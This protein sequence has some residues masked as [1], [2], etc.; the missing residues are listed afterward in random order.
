LKIAI[1]GAG[2]AGNV[3]ARGLHPRHDLTV[4]EA[5]NHIGGHS[6]TH[7]VEVGGR[8]VAVDTGFIVYNDATYPRFS[9]LLAGLGV[10]SQASSMSF[11]VRNEA[12]GLE[13]NGSTINTLFAQ[14]RNLLR[15]SF[16]RMWRD[17][18]RFNRHAPDILEH[19]A[20]HDMTLGDFVRAHN[21]SRQFVDDY[22]LPMASAIWSAAPADIGAMPARFLIGFFRNHG[23][24]SVNDRPQWRTVCGGSEQY[25]ER[26]VAPFRARIHLRTPVAGVRRAEGRVQLRL[27]SGETRQFD[28]VFF[29]CHSDQALALLED[30]SA[31]ERSILGAIPYQENEVV[32]H[33]DA[34][35]L[36]LRRRAWAAWNYHVPRT[37]IERVCVTYNMNILQALDLPQTLC[38]TLNRSA[39]IDPATIL[40]RIV[41]H[42]PLFTGTAVAAQARLHEINGVNGSYFCGAYWRYGFHE[43]GVVSGE[44]ALEWFSREVPHAQ[45][46]LYR[47]G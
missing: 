28:R 15:P 9:R 47:L 39:A 22:L 12:S 20:H 33:T 26:L 5:G 29:A 25:V 46:A 21:Y 38:V 30:A 7:H 37:P 4:F 41:Y 10:A 16:H 43:D 44:Q 3:V 32:L 45:R 27:A 17:I 8:A 11:S 24:L 19:Q 2:I 36:P 23:M 6:H 18:L 1:I 40:R 42:H 34:R 31:A 35:L 13:Y 14:R